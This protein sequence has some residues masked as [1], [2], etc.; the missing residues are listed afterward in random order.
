MA[1]IENIDTQGVEQQELSLIADRN[2]KLYSHFG[3]HFDIF[4]KAKHNDVSNVFHQL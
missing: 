4:F 3:K 1:K 2:T